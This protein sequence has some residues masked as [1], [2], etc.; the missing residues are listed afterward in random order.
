MYQ[1]HLSDGSSIQKHSAGGIY[2]YV[3]FAKQCGDS[4]RYGVIAPSGDEVLLST[5]AFAVDFALTLKRGSKQ[6]RISR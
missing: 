4:L 5:Y 2:P 1:G 6:S 3:I